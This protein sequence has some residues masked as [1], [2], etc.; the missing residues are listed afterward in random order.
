MWLQYALARLRLLLARQD[1]GMLGQF[2]TSIGLV[3]LACILAF[4]AATYV[5]PEWADVVRPA[6]LR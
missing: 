4:L 5:S 2:I 1:G 3:A 6:F